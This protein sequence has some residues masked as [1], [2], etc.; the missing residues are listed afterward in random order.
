M[1]TV[2]VILLYHGTT[3]RKIAVEKGTRLRD[4]NLLLSA[5]FSCG[6]VIGLQD[7]RDVIYPLSLVLLDPSRFA[8]GRY[9]VL[10]KNEDFQTTQHKTEQKYLNYSRESER[11]AAAQEEEEEEDDEEDDDEEENDPFF[12]FE[13]GP[14]TIAEARE[15][16]GIEGFSAEFIIDYLIEQRDRKEEQATWLMSEY[17]FETALSQLSSVKYNSSSLKQRALC[18]Y[19]VASIFSLFDETN[20]GYC[21]LRELGCGMMLFCGGEI[22]DRAQMAYQLVAESDDDDDDN[23]AVNNQYPKDGVTREMMVT[24]IASLLKVNTVHPPITNISFSIKTYLDSLFV[25]YFCSL[26]LSLFPSHHSFYS[27]FQ[28]VGVLNSSYLNSC[29]PIET[30][31]D[32]TNR[33]FVRA[34]VLLADGSCIAKDDFEY[35]FSV[36][37]TI[38]DEIGRPRRIGLLTSGSETNGDSLNSSRDYSLNDSSYTSGTEDSNLMIDTAGLDYDPEEEGDHG[39]VRET[40]PP[41]A[42]VLE[43]RDAQEKLG[44]HGVP[45][46]DLM[47]LLGELSVKGMLHI[48]AWNDFLENFTAHDDPREQALAMQLGMKIFQA[49]DPFDQDAVPYVY[50]CAGLALLTDSP[51][52]DKIMVA[53][54]LCDTS[55]NGNITVTEFQNL[56][57][58]SLK[59]AIACCS[60]AKAKLEQ[61]G[62]RATLEDLARLT[63]AEGLAV[64]GLDA[65]EPLTLELVSEIALKCVALSAAN[66]STST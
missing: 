19:I 35:W 6:D 63:V 22:I 60:L 48:D 66:T 10:S 15:A 53:F 4:L 57:L 31:E 30:A 41:S 65:D 26:F 46:E 44:L 56:V 33:A 3:I 50:F 49:F 16:V 55:G 17:Q 34:K 64:M 24:A 25:E 39:D 54:V 9:A 20:Y 29:D 47:E 12:E 2:A 36:V 32:I 18:D 45:A 61:S 21:D 51:V 38:Y 37:L 8:I 14:V 1:N 62:T 58:A 28:V 7:E 23:V 52:E 40:L 27:S 13:G 11:R 42:V 59:V 5:A 43:L